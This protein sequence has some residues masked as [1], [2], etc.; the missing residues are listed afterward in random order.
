MLVPTDRRYAKKIAV[1]SQNICWIVCNRTILFLTTY[2]FIVGIKIKTKRR[3]QDEVCS[4]RSRAYLDRFVNSK[5]NFEK[6][7]YPTCVIFRPLDPRVDS[8]VAP[9]FRQSVIQLAGESNQPVVVDLINVDF[10]DSS[11]LGALIGCYKLVQ[12]SGG[13]S[14]CNVHENVQELLSLTHMDKIFVVHSDLDSLNQ[15]AA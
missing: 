1:T 8:L 6:E 4:S 13:L 3:I 12:G 11:G 10:M 7:Q 15:R 5:M 9:E 14:L 2:L